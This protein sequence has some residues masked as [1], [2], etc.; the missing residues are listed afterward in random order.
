M[1]ATSTRLRT[2]RKGIQ[3]KSASS[4]PVRQAM[5]ASLNR[6]AMR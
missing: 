5:E 2:E 3:Q 6:R 4:S 1:Q